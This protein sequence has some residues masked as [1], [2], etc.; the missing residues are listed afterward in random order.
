MGRGRPAKYKKAEPVKTFSNSFMDD[1]IDASD[2]EFATVM[3]E[4]TLSNTTEW[5]ST[6][7]LALNGLLSGDIWKGIP[8]NKVIAFAGAEAT[9]K[10]FLCLDI[11]KDAIDK[12]Y[13]IIFFDS[14]NATDKK[15][16]VE[17]GIDPN[18]ILYMPID[19]VENFR[20]QVLR[21]VTKYNETPENKRPKILI[22]LDSLGNLSTTKE[23]ADAESGSGKRDMTR[24]QVIKSIFRTV[25]LKLAKAKIPMLITNHT[26]DTMDF[27]PS[28]K[29]SGGSGLYYAAHVIVF[30]SKS[31]AKDK[32]DEK[33]VKG[34]YLNC[35]LKKSR[36]V[37]EESSLKV[38]LDF[39][40]GLSR[41]YGL[42][43]FGMESV[44]GGYVL[45]NKEKITEDDLMTG[46][47]DVPKEDLDKANTLLHAK[48][49]FG[50]QNT[51]TIEPKKEE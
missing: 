48:F 49:A 13:I 51:E 26:Y 36:I 18:K 17:R 47:L 12:G 50:I 42:E 8:N 14:E 7:S 41:Y 4:E 46:T 31:K 10:T 3:D 38:Y 9:G 23:M 25:N 24:A 22:V 21:I 28:K 2:N 45:S 16:M 30:L 20:A 1:L 33:I 19:T 5:I 11:M 35:R 27:M 37:K 34:A 44:H 39:E 6:K 40:K 15:M 32:K 29:M 43:E